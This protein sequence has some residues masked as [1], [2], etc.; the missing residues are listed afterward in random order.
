[1]PNPKMKSA[2]VRTAEVYADFSR[3]PRMFYDTDPKPNYDPAKDKAGLYEDIDANGINTPLHVVPLA[4]SEALEIQQKH[5]LSVRPKFRIFRGHRRFDV[6]RKI[7]EVSAHKF[8]SLPVTVFEGLTPAE[9]MDLLV[10]QIQVKGLN[11]YEKYLAVKQLKL[12][13][14][15]SE[16]QIAT[17][18]GQSRGWVQRRGWIAAMPQCVEDEYRKRFMVDAE[19]KTLAH[20]RLRDEDLNKLNIAANLDRGAGLDPAEPG[21]EFMKAWT[22]LVGTGQV[23]AKDPKALTRKQM[24][25]KAA[26]VRDPIIRDTILCCAGNDIDLAAIVNKIE[27]LRSQVSTVVGPKLSSNAG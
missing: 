2:L 10:D 5:G 21:S 3:N 19:G 24:L 18:L 9:E 20:T 15:M 11:E 17:K 12:A 8:E 1:M 23:K 7:R 25:D 6:V 14:R 26:L 13:T 4:E 16:E 27:A 22:N